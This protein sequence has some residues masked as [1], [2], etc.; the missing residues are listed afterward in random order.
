MEKREELKKH[1]TNEKLDMN[2]LIAQYFSYVYTVVRNY[3][4]SNMSE[5]D[6]EEIILDVF[7]A[8]WN[9]RNQIKDNIAI[10]SYLAGIARNII[11]KRYRDNKPTYS[12]NEYESVLFDTID[13][14]KIVILKE[15]NNFIQDTLK[16]M[17]EEDYNIFIMFYYEGKKIDEIAKKLDVSNSK[18][19][20]SLHRIR[21]KIKISLNKG[22]YNYGE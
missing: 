18:I 19:K 9:N 3:K 2:R 7:I 8:I 21:K 1:I 16:K 12:L 4:N 13:M 6:V 5:E 14:D 22:G 11:Y 20:V 15:Q 10:T 17:K